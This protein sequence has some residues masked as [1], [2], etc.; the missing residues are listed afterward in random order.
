MII[1]I[2][3]L[4]FFLL[5][6]T[7]VYWLT[8]FPGYVYLAWNHWTIHIS[9]LWYVSGTLLAFVILY[10]LT[11]LIIYLFVAPSRIR[12]HIETLKHN[13][14]RQELIQ[15]MLEYTQGYWKK[16]EKWLI[17][18]VDYSDTPVLNYL[19]AAYA[20]Q[21][22]KKYENRDLY[23]R[24]A[25]ASNPKARLAVELSQAHLQIEHGQDEQALATLNHLSELKPN[26]PYILELLSKL[27][28]E[29]EDWE[30]LN[31]LLPRIQKIIKM[32]P[33]KFKQIEE[34]IIVGKI[35]QFSSN[36]IEK[37]SKFWN[38][39]SKEIQHNNSIVKAYTYFLIKNNQYKS[40]LKLIEKAINHSWNNELME[41]W[42]EI[43]DQ[44]SLEYRLKK[45]EE[46]LIQYPQNAAL[47]LAA[48]RLCYRQKLWGKADSYYRASIIEDPNP[49]AYLELGE[50]L[51]K[52]QKSG[53]ALSHFHTGLKESIK[54]ES[55]Q[56]DA[57]EKRAQTYQYENK[58][59]DEKSIFPLTSHK[60]D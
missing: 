52:D 49:I 16:S 55:W 48:A 21:R 39:L 57:K 41:F 1:V 50:L 58:I 34:D 53:E 44:N 10:L 14:A 5:L 42:G 19:A 60:N 17:H 25:I 46:W 7:G 43:Y 15:G 2:G 11:R 33:S 9:L 29:K 51:I 40:A 24:K 30:S 59:Q 32:D 31:T 8:N 56:Q 22:Q 18:N 12:K 3:S 35:N 38:S 37:A 45:A 47:L 26:H 28:L 54:R 13:K 27:Y 4:I 6:G 23:L 20:A 36:D